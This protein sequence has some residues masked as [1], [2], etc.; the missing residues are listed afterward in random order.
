MLILC[1]LRL[2][3]KNVGL[4]DP[5]QKWWWLEDWQKGE[6]EAQK[7]VEEGRVSKTYDTL[8]KALAD[9]MS[10]SLGSQT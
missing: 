8:D 4:I 10:D 1:L 7:E 3:L 5:E 6:R 2:I 9:L